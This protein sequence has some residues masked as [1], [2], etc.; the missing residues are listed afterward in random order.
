[1]ADSDAILLLGIPNAD[2]ICYCD[3]PDAA[4]KLV[5][6]TER[7]GLVSGPISLARLTDSHLVNGNAS[8]D[9]VGAVVRTGTIEVR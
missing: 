1:M 7:L 9:L 2:G 6:D 5:V 3:A 8:I 4:G